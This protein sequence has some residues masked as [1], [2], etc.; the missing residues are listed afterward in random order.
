MSE[1]IP[2]I[3]FPQ[4]GRARLVALLLSLVLLAGLALLPDSRTQAEPAAQTTAPLS[5]TI[6][7]TGS[8]PPGGGNFLINTTGQV[9]ITVINS[10][11]TALTAGTITLSI[12]LPGGMTYQTPLTSLPNNLFTC[13]QVLSTVNCANTGGALDVSG[14]E[15]VSFQVL[16]PST[17]ATGLRFSVLGFVSGFTLPAVADDLI[18]FSILAPTATITPSFTPSQ[19]PT[20]TPT[21]TLFPSITP[22][23]TITPPPTAT[24]IPTATLIPNPP[25]RTPPPRPANAGQAVG[26]I[27]RPGVRVVVDRDNVNI[28]IIPAIGAE[29]IAFVNAGSTYDILA[30]SP[31]N[32]FVQVIVGN[33][34]GWLGTA[35]VAI[36]AG[37]LNAAPVADPRTIPYGGFEN[38]RSGITSASSAITGRLANSGLRVRSGPGLG[39]PVLANAPRFTVFPLLGQALG[40]SWLQVNFEGTL[41]WV[42]TEFVELQQGLGVIAGLPEDGIVADGLPISE[43][44]TDSYTDTLRLLLARVELAQPSLD[45]IR[46]IW[47]SIAIGDRA[48]CGSY[49]PRPSDYNIP[50]PVLAPFFGTLDP[51]QTDFNEAMRLVRLAI[52]LLIDICSRPQPPAGFV[53][54]A[55]VQQALDAINRADGLFASLRARLRELLPPDVPIGDDQ[56]LFTFN[57]RSEVL[58][59]LFLN[60]PKI[61]TLRDPNRRVVGLCFDA[62]AGQTLSVQ[63]LRVTGNAQARLTVTSFDNPTNF[64]G[65]A[66]FGSDGTSARISSILFTQT[67]RYLLLISDL[68]AGARGVRL[69][70][71]IAV[72]LT[73]TSA[74]L[75]ID[76]ATGNVIVQQGIFIPSATPFTSLGGGVLPGGTPVIGG[77]VCPSVT[78]TCQQL[79]TCE[80]AR[81]CVIFN[82]ALDPLGSGTPCPNLCGG[83]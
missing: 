26:P 77:V 46:A 63:G 64:L 52:D 69:Q 13:S 74:S 60:T 65:V 22:F 24:P 73:D 1:R 34:L 32:E 83:G 67:G 68:D 4:G 37:D 30:R 36:I 80:Q 53:G 43:P 71:E 78:F 62:G 11:A 17:P 12:P 15:V 10:G 61:V 56:C 57:R 3:G 50:N 40:G 6:T 8:D 54:Q 28:R 48:A 70:G 72:L 49:P 5:L 45:A 42:A 41:G 9:Q 55:V 2:S 33:Q 47:T 25:T 51:L 66:E 19:T 29:V 76:P 16:A 23:P 7:H 44:T 58:D 31:D 38:P 59:R 79:Q 18:P 21:L 35:V 20:R 14:I 27:P 39:Y 82:P 75:A 81:A